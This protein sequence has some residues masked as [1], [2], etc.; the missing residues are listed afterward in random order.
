MLPSLI[1]RSTIALAL[2]LIGLVGGIGTGLHW[3]FGCSHH[4]HCSDSHCSISDSACRSLSSGNTSC[5]SDHCSSAYC[6][7]D[8]S[9]GHRHRGSHSPEGVD[10]TLVE[11]EHDCAICQLLSQFH[12]SSIES[13][14]LHVAWGKRVSI[15]L[16]VPEVPA[17]SAHRLEHPRGP[18]REC[19]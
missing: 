14:S 3:I 16:S 5:C 11:S 9:I 4:C 12:S 10:G 18:P 8:S 7:S 15:A 17:D 1:Q 6:H 13:P 2:T 19:S